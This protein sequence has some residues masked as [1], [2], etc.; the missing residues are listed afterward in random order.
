M[1]ADLKGNTNV[2]AELWRSRNDGQ[3]YWHVKSHGNHNTLAHSEGYTT[4]AAALHGLRL[5]YDGPVR[6]L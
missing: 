4:K 2:Y 3:Y 6:E 5:V 1:H